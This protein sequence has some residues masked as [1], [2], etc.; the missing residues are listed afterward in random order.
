[1]L[2]KYYTESTDRNKFDKTFSRAELKLLS[3]VVISII[4]TAALITS[5][6]YYYRNLDLKLITTMRSDA[7]FSL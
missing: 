4:I 5:I 1:M 6:F 3:L 7:I 2:K